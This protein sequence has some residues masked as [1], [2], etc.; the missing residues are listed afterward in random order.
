MPIVL[1]LL[2]GLISGEWFL[3]RQRGLP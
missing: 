1:L 3:R 2:I